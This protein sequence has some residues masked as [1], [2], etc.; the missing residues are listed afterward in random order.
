MNPPTF[1]S[2]LTATPPAFSRT[3]SGDIRIFNLAL[4]PPVGTPGGDYSFT[5][6]VLDDQNVDYL[7]K[8][9][10]IHVIPPVPLPVALNNTNLAWATAPSLPWFGQTNVSHDSVASGRSFFIGDGQQCS[11]TTTTNGPGTLSFWWKVS[12]QTNADVLSFL[13]YGGGTTNL[14]AQISGETGWQQLSVL[15]GGGSQTLVW[16][17]SKDASLSAGLDAGFV[18]QVSYVFGPTLPYI[19]TNPV[20]QQVSAGT[21]VTF[22]VLADGTPVLAYQ[23]GLN[24]TDVPGA[25]SNVFTLPVPGYEDSGTYSVRVSNPY[26]TTNS[27]NAAL[28]IIPLILGGDNS[29]GQTDLP[30]AATNLVAIAAGSWHNLGLRANGTVLAWGNDYEGQCDVPADLSNALAIAAGG[31]HSLAIQADGTVVAWGANDYGQTTIPAGLAQVIGISAGTWHSL[32]LRRDGTVKAWG[33]NT[34]AQSSVPVGLSNVLAVAAGGN[35]SLALRTNGTVVAWGQNTDA[36]GNIAG[37][38]VV[39][40][41]LTGV[42]A[43][44]AGEYHSLAVRSNGTVVAWGDNSQ[45]Q[46]SVP[47]GLSNV[48]AVAGGGAHSLAL[49]ASGAVVAWGCNLSGQCNPASTLAK[50]VALAAGEDHSLL[51]ASSA[52]PTP[53]LLLPVRTPR[54]FSLLI[55]TLCGKHYAL[56]CKNSLMATNWSTLS[57]NAGNGALELLTD[58]TATTA[59]RFYRLRQW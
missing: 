12:S 27:A 6:H 42:V 22:S 29:L 5:L 11:L 34:W 36:E 15:L 3:C 40:L 14:T 21:P 48:V 35:H 45:G 17:Y 9:V 10:L 28:T 24:G 4:T 39:P 25:T 55:Q 23:W 8:S 53:K 2:W 37:Q 44:A 19:I 33:D 38:S 16:I 46:T 31:Y 7:D 58:R 1:S 54:T 13:S 43:I 56:D 59:Q 47:P 26:G 51:L 32:A 30:T 41:G 49:T 50:V 57:T 18:D 20:S 52:L